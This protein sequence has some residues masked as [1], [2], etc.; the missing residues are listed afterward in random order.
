MA[1]RYKIYSNYLQEKYGEKVYKIP[2]NLPVTCPNRDGTCGTGGCIFC[3]EKGAGFEN[4]PAVMPVR[5]QLQKNKDYIGKKYKAKKFI[6]YFQ[7]F[8]NTYLP[9][10]MFKS[11]VREACVKDVTELCISTRPDCV[12]EPYMDFLEELRAGMGINISIELGVQTVNYHSLKIINR[13]H[14]LAE[15]IDAM[16]L[17]NKYSFDTCAHLI[18]N[19]PWDNMDDVIENAKI[20]SSL[21]FRQVK[22][23]ALYI[24]KNTVMGELYSRESLNMITREEYVDRVITFLEY[25]DPSIV[26]QRF[27]GRAP[28]ENTLFVNW[29]TSWWK[30]KD[31]VD[32][33]MELQD[34]RQGKHFNYLGGSAL[35]FSADAF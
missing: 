23:H 33:K 24:V 17:L 10:D 9:L 22:L 21:K 2:V 15:V 32:E 3:G 29:N 34:S 26:I 20:I 5:E 8:S 7:N 31:M 35:K 30:I 27:I 28:E 14:T 11:Y 25:L 18:L 6:A 1:E 13:G 12:A 4:L 19:L 16:M